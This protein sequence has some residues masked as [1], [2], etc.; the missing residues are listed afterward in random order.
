MLDLVVLLV[1]EDDG[2]VVVGVDKDVQRYWH[3]YRRLVGIVGGDD[4]VAG[5]GAWLPG[6]SS[7]R[8]RQPR[9]TH[10]E[11]RCRWLDPPSAHGISGFSA[12]TSSVPL[13]LVADDEISSHPVVPVV[14][15]VLSESGAMLGVSPGTAGGPRWQATRSSC[16]DIVNHRVAH[17][18]LGVVHDLIERPQRYA[19]VV[20]LHEPAAR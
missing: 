17:V 8:P 20:K 19:G 3:S 15:V 11:V 13:F 4:Q 16:P 2:Q 18:E 10:L 9:C 7:R 6:R 12:A 14:S 1:L 5:V